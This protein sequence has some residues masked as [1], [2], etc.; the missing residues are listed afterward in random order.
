MGSDDVSYEPVA[1][2]ARAGRM[3]CGAVKKD[4]KIIEG[5]GRPKNAFD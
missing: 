4:R 2:M 5:I 1:V 3:L